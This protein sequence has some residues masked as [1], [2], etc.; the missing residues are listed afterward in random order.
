MSVGVGVGWMLFL[1]CED[2]FMYRDYV[3]VRWELQHT[4]SDG[5]DERRRKHSDVFARYIILRESLLNWWVIQP[6]EVPPRHTLGRSP[7]LISASRM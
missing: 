1:F 2:D 7:D 5:W 3:G 6:R 4:K